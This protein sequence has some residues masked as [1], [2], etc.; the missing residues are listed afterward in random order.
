MKK[1]LL[2]A[3]IIIGC[4]KVTTSVTESLISCTDECGGTAWYVDD[5]ECVCE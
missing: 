2:I 5:G 1:L 4:D 3:F